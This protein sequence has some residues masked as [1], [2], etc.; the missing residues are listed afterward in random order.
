MQSVANNLGTIV[1]NK[2]ESDKTTLFHK[3]E[4]LTENFDAAAEKI[5]IVNADCKISIIEK[6]PKKPAVRTKIPQRNDGARENSAAKA[7]Q[8]SERVPK[9]SFAIE[10]K[11]ISTA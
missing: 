4:C 6:S 9:G 8:P 2:T 3:A 7:A 11:K 1:Q 10:I 5:N